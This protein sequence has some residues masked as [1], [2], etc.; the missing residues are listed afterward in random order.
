MWEHAQCRGQRA[1]QARIL[2]PGQLG[3]WQ[4]MRQKG[5]GAGPSLPTSPQGLPSK[6]HAV[7]PPAP[8]GDHGL[9][10]L[11][12]TG[13]GAFCDK[14]KAQ[15]ASSLNIPGHPPLCEYFPDSVSTLG[16]A[17]VTSVLPEGTRLNTAVC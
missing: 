10:T 2:G 1:L 12:S 11:P 13:E 9:G 17:D 7:Q 14:K 8:T 3:L 6:S 4:E 15:V 5:V 16:K